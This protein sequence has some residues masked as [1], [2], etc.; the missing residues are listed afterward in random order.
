MNDPHRWT[1]EGG[2]ATAL[3]RDL[4]SAGRDA[5]PSPEQK[6]TMWGAIASQAIPPSTGPGTAPAVGAAASTGLTVIKG[7]AILV[8]LGAGIVASYRTMRGP[9]PPRTHSSAPAT[10][11]AGPPPPPPDEQPPGAS[12]P[13]V[14]A[15]AAEGPRPVKVAVHSAPR[16]N[17]VAA[18]A[19][20]ES[21]R[22]SQLREE[23][24]MILG[25]RRL[26]RA[27]DSAG[28]LTLLDAARTRFA[29]GG[30]VQEREA[31]TIEALVRSGQRALATKR[32]EAF[33]RDY[34][35]SPHGADV[36]SLVLEP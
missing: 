20:A 9:I 6:R 28:A 33:L 1:D 25:A 21:M 3:E 15:P 17:A 4:V 18:A 5:G 27:G 19:L 30:L 23:S 34:P 8:L 26:L 13:R 10:A 32:A 31:L 2:E 11:P 22:A 14:G 29:D 7:A 24:A 36:R 35:K 12:P 16:P